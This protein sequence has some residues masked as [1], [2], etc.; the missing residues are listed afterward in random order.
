MRVEAEAA[1]AALGDKSAPDWNAVL[2]DI[3]M[4]HKV[5]APSPN[6]LT[7]VA[8]A[9][10]SIRGVAGGEEFVYCATTS[11]YM[12]LGAMMLTAQHFVK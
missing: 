4:S 12:N 7:Y 11:G 5:A 2:A 3:A 1:K 10:E 6:Q 8:H 9:K